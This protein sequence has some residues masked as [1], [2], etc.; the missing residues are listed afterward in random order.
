M[1][2]AWRS[3]IGAR[4]EKNGEADELTPLRVVWNEY[5]AACPPLTT[6]ALRAVLGAVARGLKPAIG[7]FTSRR[8]VSRE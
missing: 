1:S 2:V 3:A 6:P 8:R 7:Q 4:S 5:G